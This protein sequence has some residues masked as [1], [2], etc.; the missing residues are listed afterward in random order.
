[1]QNPDPTETFPALKIGVTIESIQGHFL[2]A[3]RNIKTSDDL[4][5]V[6]NET[7]NKDLQ[8]LLRISNQENYFK[9]F[10]FKFTER[11]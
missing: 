6:M 10:N 9:V 5:K 11:Q 8:G 7:M 1:M 3:K 2:I 4:I